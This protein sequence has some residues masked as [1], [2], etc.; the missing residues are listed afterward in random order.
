L[1]DFATVVCEDKRSATLDAGNVKLTYNALLEKAES[2]DKERV[3]EEARK[4]R[5]LEVAFRNMLNE[6]GINEED[7]WDDVREKVQGEPAFEAIVQEYERVRIF[8]EFIKVR[9]VME[10]FNFIISINSGFL[11]F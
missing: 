10:L 8:K 6:R 2:K 3:K 9:D 7:V 5:K 1:Q 11:L 4:G